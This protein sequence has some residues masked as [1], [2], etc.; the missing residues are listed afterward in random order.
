MK[1]DDL[2]KTCGKTKMRANMETP[3]SQNKTKGSEIVNKW[4]KENSGKHKEL[5]IFC[6]DLSH[7]IRQMKEQT[8]T[9]KIY[10]AIPTNS[11]IPQ[12]KFRQN[13]GMVNFG[14]D[15]LPLFNFVLKFCLYDLRNW[16]W[17]GIILSCKS[18][19]KRFPMT[20]RKDEYKNLIAHGNKV[21]KLLQTKN[22]M[23][24]NLL[25]WKLIMKREML[26]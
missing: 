13:V 15:H 22:K 21:T 26:V 9:R 5:M 17:N 11:T 12:I 24:C 6:N 2:Q 18:F 23:E 10:N 7:W 4:N 25:H 14:G 16:P 1:A 19:V 8:K 20:L 3:T